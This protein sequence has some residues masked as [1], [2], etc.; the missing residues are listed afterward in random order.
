M[1]NAMSALYAPMQ[2]RWH[3]AEP[4]GR[5]ASMYAGVIPAPGSTGTSDSAKAGLN[6]MRGGPL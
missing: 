2:L 1:K 3:P 6:G 5:Q 4:V